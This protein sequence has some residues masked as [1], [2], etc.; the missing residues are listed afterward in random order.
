[1][2]RVRRRETGE[3]APAE[4]GTFRRMLPYALGVWHLLAA[5]FLCIAAVSLLELATPWVMG[6]VL[7]DQVIGRQ[8]LGR[9]PFVVGMLAA[10]FVG[11][12]FASFLQEY[13]HEL[14]SQRFIHRLR[15]DF[16]EKLQ[17]LPL[18]F[19][20]QRRSGELVARATGDVDTV[21]NLLRTLIQDVATEFF[22]L[23]GTVY[24]MFLMSPGLTLYVLP[25]LVGLAASVFFFKRTAK[26]FARR[27]RAMLGEMAGLA[28]ETVAGVRVVK[29]F[30]AEMFEVARFSAKSTELLR[31]RV[32]MAKLQSVYSSTVDLWVFGGTAVVIY[33]AT[34]RVVAGELEIGAMVTYLA[35]LQKLYGPAKKLSKVSFSIQKIM[36]SADRIFEVMTL[37]GESQVIHAE[38]EASVPAR[39]IAPAPVREKPAAAPTAPAVRF[40]HVTLRYDDGPAAL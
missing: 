30:S 23:V 39:R 36:A 17:R 12:K 11:H 22:L 37:P 3:A 26:K 13:F 6:V 32:R 29:A 24:F 7:I 5:L 38:P 20:E 18:G 25:T 8:D 1:M 4:P 27:V 21:E 31:S 33:M 15:C 40:E 14:S 35:Y 10:I 16:F 19:F 34:P 9:L 28:T 2:R